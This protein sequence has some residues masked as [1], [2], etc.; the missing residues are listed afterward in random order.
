MK[1]LPPCLLIVASSAFPAF[2]Q[3]AG[4]STDE[5]ARKLADPG[6]QPPQQLVDDVL[7]GDDLQLACGFGQ[8]TVPLGISVSKVVKLDVAR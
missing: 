2:A 1:S 7:L 6:A 8:W 3:E 4:R 5:I